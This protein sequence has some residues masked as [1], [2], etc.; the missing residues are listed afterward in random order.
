MPMCKS[1]RQLA[2]MRRLHHKC[3]RLRLHWK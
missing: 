3:N 2:D 1:A